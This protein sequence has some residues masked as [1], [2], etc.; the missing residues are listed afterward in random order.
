ML[1]LAYGE[2]SK[3]FLNVTFPTHPNNSKTD[4]DLQ[5]QRLN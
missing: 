4:S 5:S 3:L 1:L 2:D